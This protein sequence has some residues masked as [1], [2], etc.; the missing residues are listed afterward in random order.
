MA[1]RSNETNRRMDQFELATHDG[2]VP[3]YVD[4]TTRVISKGVD[5]KPERTVGGVVTPAADH[6]IFMNPGKA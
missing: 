6:I 5:G 4:Q 2:G 3:V 1:R